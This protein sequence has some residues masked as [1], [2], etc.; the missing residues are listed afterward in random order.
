[1]SAL[2]DIVQSQTLK[3]PANKPTSTFYV[4]QTL[5]VRT[6]LSVLRD[7]VS[8]KTALKLPDLFAWILMNAAAV[9]TY[10]AIK[11]IV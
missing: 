5:T 9:Q 6:M 7:N 1:M 11:Q 4:A 10:A 8:V 3:L 2:K